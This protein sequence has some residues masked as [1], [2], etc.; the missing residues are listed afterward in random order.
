LLLFQVEPN[1]RKIEE[2]RKRYQRLY[3]EREMKK[4]E[5]ERQRQAEAR[6]IRVYVI[7]SSVKK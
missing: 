1:A 7:L 5:R 2:H 4:A 6:V 3:K